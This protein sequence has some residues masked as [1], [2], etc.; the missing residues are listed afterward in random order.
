MQAKSLNQK[1]FDH[2]PNTQLS[3]NEMERILSRIVFILIVF[4]WI[5]FSQTKVITDTEF[6]FG[7]W[8]WPN[9]G[10]KYVEFVLKRDGNVNSISVTG[11][12]LSQSFNH[13]EIIC[14]KDICKVKDKKMIVLKLQKI[15][16]SENLKILDSDIRDFR[17]EKKGKIIVKDKEPE[18]RQK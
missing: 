15:A 5:I 17:L 10:I 16:G 1:Y 2:L 11:F 4:P 14:Y 3:D 12:E 8:Y 7:T 18:F 6:L 9:D 13:V